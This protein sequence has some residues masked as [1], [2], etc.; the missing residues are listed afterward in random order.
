MNLQSSIF[1]QDTLTSMLLSAGV[2]CLLSVILEKGKPGTM[3]GIG[4]LAALTYACTAEIL[5]RLSQ[6]TQIDD[7]VK[8]MLA[9]LVYCFREIDEGIEQ[10]TDAWEKR[11]YWVKAEEFRRKWYWVG[12]MEAELKNMLMKEAWDQ[13]PGL[14]VRLLPHFADIKITK[15]MRKESAWEGSYTKLMNEQ[16]PS[17]S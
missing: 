6:K 1:N 13:L 3:A 2:S 8:D 17:A 9:K 7:E 16:P 12:L 5:R 11:D 4:A 14:I 15:F 10:A